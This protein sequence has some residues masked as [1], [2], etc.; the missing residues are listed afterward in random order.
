[1]FFFLIEKQKKTFLFGIPQI[2]DKHI[3]NCEVGS[4]VLFTRSL[5]DLIYFKSRLTRMCYAEF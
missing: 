4:N 1:M 2:L 5:L 3:P